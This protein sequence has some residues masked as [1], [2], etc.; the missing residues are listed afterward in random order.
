MN[1]GFV[2][3]FLAFGIT[4][5]TIN[6]CVMLSKVETT[7]DEAVVETDLPDMVFDS[8]KLAEVKVLYE[9]WK[10]KYIFTTVQLD[11]DQEQIYSDAYVYYNGPQSWNDAEGSSNTVFTGSNA[12]GVIYGGSEDH[13]NRLTV[14]EA[15]GYGM[16][17]AAQMGDEVLFEE[18]YKFYIKFLNDNGFMKWAI[19][20]NDFEYG[21][22]SS[23]YFPSY[24]PSTSRPTKQMLLPSPGSTATSPIL[25]EGSDA[26]TDGDLDIA[27]ALILANDN[28]WGDGKYGVAAQRAIDAI[29]TFVV[30]SKFNYLKI[31]D[32]DV[33]GDIYDGENWENF[34]YSRVARTSDFQL[35]NIL[36]FKKFDTSHKNAWQKVYDTTVKAIEDCA[37]VDGL[38]PDF[39]YF[40]ENSSSVD[41]LWSRPLP[42]VQ[43]AKSLGFTNGSLPFLEGENDGNYYFNASRTPWRISAPLAVGV[44]NSK[45]EDVITKWFA[46]AQK[47]ENRTDGAVMA[48]FDLDGN[49]LP[50]SDYG[51]MVFDAPFMVSA[52]ALNDEIALNNYWSLYVTDIVSGDD[53]WNQIGSVNADKGFY[54]YF[55]D[56]VRLGAAISV[57]YK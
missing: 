39:I 32:T 14:S 25:V 40:S 49:V 37:T 54:N 52:K 30:H 55:D 46:W 18:L 3:L 8:T 13:P 50:Y 11:T 38:L 19:R 16:L 57:A 22:K 53:K 4:V 6:S 35:I 2:K 5:L 44:K 36:A 10:A 29:R 28:G 1:K 17:A 15:H 41:T 20:F 56:T 9:A 47:P 51:S 7:M 27:Y 24:D 31:G 42:S 48:G 12:N 45:I 33:E 21:E 26:A 43:E 23:N 34:D